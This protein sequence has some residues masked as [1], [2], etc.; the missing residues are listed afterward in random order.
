MEL[1]EG[2]IKLNDINPRGLDFWKEMK[3]CYRRRKLV[4]LLFFLD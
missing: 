4:D 3:W 2:T 1:L